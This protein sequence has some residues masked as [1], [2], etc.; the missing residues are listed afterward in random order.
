MYN[1]GQIPDIVRVKKALGKFEINK[2]CQTVFQRNSKTVFE[3]HNNVI[4]YKVRSVCM[5]DNRSIKTEKL[6]DWRIPYPP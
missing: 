4:Y 5:T 1:S 6:N 2:K 3:K